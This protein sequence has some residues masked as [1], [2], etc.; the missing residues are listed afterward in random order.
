MQPTRG[1]DQFFGWGGGGGGGKSKKN[2]E[3]F[4][5]RAKLQDKILAAKRAAKLK[6]FSSIFYVKFNGF[7]VPILCFLNLF[8]HYILQHFQVVEIIGGGQND[9]FAP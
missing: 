6:M 9:M 5:A 4:G 3:F 8:L 2:F 1:V 7:V